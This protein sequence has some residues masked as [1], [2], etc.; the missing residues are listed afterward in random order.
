MCG[1]N[2]FHHSLLFVQRQHIFN[3]IQDTSKLVSSSLIVHKRAYK[4]VKVGNGSL[5]WKLVLEASLINHVCENGLYI[6]TVT[7][8]IRR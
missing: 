5:C 3:P 1:V 7:I 4:R 2:A 8:K 6:R